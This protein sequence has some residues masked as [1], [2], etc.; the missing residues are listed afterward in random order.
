MMAIVDD[1]FRS[2]RSVS[3][4]EEAPVFFSLSFSAC[5]MRTLDADVCK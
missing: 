4:V 5:P 3:K 1:K 2:Q